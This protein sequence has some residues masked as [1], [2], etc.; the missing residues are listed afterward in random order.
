MTAARA[1]EQDEVKGAPAEPADAKQVREQIAA[2]VKLQPTLPD[3][4]AALYFLAAAKQHLREDRDALA[5]LKDCLALREGFD[6]SGD[7]A[8]LE[9]K[10]TR[11][12]TTLIDAVHRDFPVVAQAREAF[13][14]TEKDLI[15][16]GLAF[17]SLRNV[18]YLSSLNRRKIVETGRD[19]TAT[20]FVPT[21]RYDLLPV[22]GIRLS[23]SDGT[24]WADSFADTGQTELL[25]FDAEG[26]LLGRFKPGG[27]GMHGFNDLVVR[28]NGDVITTDSLANAVFR[29][30]PATRTFTPL[31]LHRP[32]FYPNGIALSGD[33]HTLYV[34]DN[35]GVVAL[36]L[37][38]GD[39]RD[40]DPGARSTLAG[41]DGLYWY[42]GSLVSVQN[43]IGSPRVAMFRLSRDGLRVTRTTIL[44]NR[45]NFTV[46]PTTGAI[47]RSDF[48]FIA[49][50][51]ID[52]L[53]N[54]KVMD[55]TKLEVVRVAVLRLP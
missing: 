47:R 22:L 20:D 52:N 42:N 53:N 30:D 17:D 12:F 48:Y 32:V 37:L 39:S 35:L 34:A 51:Q 7:P 43:G 26:K 36:G 23:P 31:R 18:F 8:F 24:L 16:E 50:S 41:I 44:E 9:L 49:N 2:V 55:A 4:G 38:K 15:P 33:E 40:V 13:R 28:K 25:H 10:G 27:A 6:P 3:R 1:Q 29:F 11:E 54:D 46:L 45:T 14:T 5:L 19:G 21:D